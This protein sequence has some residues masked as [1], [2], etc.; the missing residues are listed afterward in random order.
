MR[1]LSAKARQ[2]TASTPAKAIPCSTDMKCDRSHPKTFEPA[3]SVVKDLQ[4]TIAVM[5][6]DGFSLATLAGILEPIRIAN[7]LCDE[8]RLVCT[9]IGLAG[10]AAVCSAGLEIDL[11]DCLDAYA[12]KLSFE[13]PDVFVIC[14]GERVE[15]QCSLSLRS[16]LSRLNRKGVELHAV[17][18]ASWLLADAGLLEGRECTIHWTKAA[19]FA[20]KYRDV[21]IQN[22]ILL[23]DGKLFSSPGELATFDLCLSL[24]ARILGDDR[25]ELVS[26]YLVKGLVRH[27]ETRQYR[28]HALRH[29]A[30]DEN[31]S[32]II[33][34]MEDNV[35]SA[36]PMKDILGKLKLSRRQIERI[37]RNKLGSTPYQYYRRMRLE[38][39]RDLLRSSDMSILDISI[40]CGFSSASQFNKSFRDV[41]SCRPSDMKGLSRSLQDHRIWRS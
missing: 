8:A 40:A 12:R 20:E 14:S 29:A 41:F 15:K 6:V 34:L 13:T 26:E 23:N 37:F 7:Q 25:A 3:V 35:S 16:L 21:R 10:K 2:S 32:S 27:P 5:V 9:T 1:T 28:P 33:D 36:R 18:T 38:R 4:K 39:S 17:G 30:L 31:L 11:D 19:S 22:R 24:I